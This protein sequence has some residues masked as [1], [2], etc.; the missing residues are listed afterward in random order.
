MTDPGTPA[1]PATFRS[2]VAVGEFRALWLAQLVSLVG[3]QLARV[4]LA[5]L[6]FGRTGSPLLT[7]LVYALTFLPWL[8]GG[9]LL[10]GLADRYPRRRVMLATD[11]ARAL[12]VGPMAVPGVPLPVLSGLLVAAVAFNSP[13]SAARA[14][15]LPDVLP[16]DRY[17]L[18]SA[19]GNV[20]AESAQVLGFAL[21]GALVALI[22]AQQALA[23]DAATFLASALVLRL[24]VR[25]RPAPEQAGLAG[26]LGLVSGARHVFS[27]PRLRVLVGLAWLAAAYV[28]PEGLAVP[29][30]ADLGYGATAVG[31]L[32]AANPVGTVIGGIVVSRLLTPPRRLRA[33]RPLALLSC[34][35]LIGCW[36]QPGLTVSL[37]LWA[38]SG[39]G[40]A[41]MLAANVAFVQAVPNERRAR[42]F[43]VV[44]TG[45]V[46]GQGAAI[47]LAGL[48]AEVIA[49]H[50]VVAVAGLVGVAAAAALAATPAL[51]AIARAAA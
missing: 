12:L 27:R 39:F 29:Y 16:D 41:Y 10:A 25:N 8:I 28:V 49:P 15:L 44:Q 31:L 42:C 43:A 40:S 20:T 37:L 17:V 21:G 45:L 51:R 2:V 3:D 35:P 46:V 19:I 23:I 32:L 9:P 47:V 30:A 48:L 26:S 36:W 13:F 33:M 50:Q 18:A 14:A 11:V 24:G 38:L 4:A 22:G 6:V 34:A 7:G 5:V 1:R